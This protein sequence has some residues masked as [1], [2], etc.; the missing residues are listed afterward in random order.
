VRN[1]SVV[2][3]QIE[4][5]KMSRAEQ[6][7]KQNYET[8]NLYGPKSKVKETD[9]ADKP[10]EIEDSS[11]GKK[12][13]MYWVLPQKGKKYTKTADAAEEN[14][15]RVPKSRRKN[16]NREEKLSETFTK[17]KLDLPKPVKVTIHD[18]LDNLD[19]H[20]S[21]QKTLKDIPFDHKQLRSM[22]DFPLALQQNDLMTDIFDKTL[23]MQRQVSFTPSVSKVLQATMSPSQKNALI[24]WKNLK[25]AELGLEGFEKMQKEYL[26]RGKLF[27]ECVQKYFNS[28]AISEDNLPANIKELWTSMSHVLDEFETP[29][30]ATEQ[31]IFHP[32]L[33]YKGIVDC[34]SV[35]QKT[36]ALSVIE[37]K[38]SDRHKKS[39]SS[40]F[41]AP[42]QLCAYLGALNATQFQSDPLQSGIIVVAYN[43][44][45]SA[46]LFH[47]SANELNKYWK[48][49]LNRLQEY[50]V[51]YRDN[52]LADEEI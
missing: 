7:K 15:P 12:S 27:H 18:A 9:V 52:T 6:I 30:T 50:W 5:T 22:L 10:V 49:W 23:I 17:F 20:T 14:E 4:T 3:R 42:L 19:L 2:I 36:R 39:V 46:D 31:A 24:Q 48:L 34:V 43:D 41:D 29:A 47:L 38:N 40:T 11:N 13:E 26:S 21:D 33:R 51:R 44:G 32:H 28:N 8:A 35:H 25:I 1:K 45:Q 16:A 37:W